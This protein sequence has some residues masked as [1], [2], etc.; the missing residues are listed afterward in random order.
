MKK[1]I[2]LLFCSANAI[3]FN[4]QKKY[5]FLNP[6]KFNEADLSKAKSLL[7]ENAPAEILYKS[8][9][10]MVDSNTGNLH[11]RY[12]YR[13][14]IYNKDKAEDWLNLE[15]PIYNVGTNR[16]SLGKFKAFTYNLENG[17]AVPV[18]VEKSSQYK[19]KENKYVTLTKFAFPSVKNGSVI[20]YQY[21]IISP[22]RFMIP[23]VLI[24]SDTPSLNTEYVFDTPINMSYNVNYTGGISPKYR[25]M[26]ERQLYGG[27][28][29]TYR[30]AYE[31]LTGF[32]TEKFVRNDRNFRTKISAELNSTNFGELKL[33]SSS[34]DQIAKR[35]Y[36]SDDFG[37]EIKRTKLARENMPA[38]VSEMKT[39]L[40]KANAIFSYVQKTFT[41]NKD[42]GVYTEDGIKKLLETKTGNAA[43][44]NLFLVM[45]LREAGLKADPLIISTVENGLINMVSPNISNMNFVLAAI[46]IDKQLHIYDA[47]SKQSSLDEIPLKNWNQYGILVTKDKA[48]QIQMSNVK[49]SNTYLTANA[50]INDDGSISGTY[51]DK[52][53]GAYAM[54][55]K[56]NYDDNAEKYKKQ[57]KENFSMDFT[58]INSKVLENGDFESTM[59]F[60]SS[61]LIDRVG[62]KMIINPMLFLSKNSNEFDQTEVRKYPI[63]FGSPITRTKKVIL[64]IPEGYKI[65]EMPK[66][67]RIVTEDKEI[68]YTYSV[69]QK[70]NMLEVTTTTKIG[71]SDYPKEYYPAFKQIWGVA[72][73]FENQ[74]ISLVKK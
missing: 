12:F 37:G 59:K 14:K 24:E 29:R 4:A 17:A 15:I 54:Y 5:E 20:E 1:I 61:N 7:D 6:P 33:Y 56:D 55:A 49:S 46:D 10:F 68:A 67:K 32:K 3:L 9:Y 26:E 31:N 42:K 64:E 16:E 34:W 2:V 35:L 58:D 13:V 74:V 72:S 22:F 8:A 39:D 52:D 71:S 44:I 28:Y 69:E 27:Q 73:K 23:E 53:T 51:S 11:K 21:E 45:M 25:E 36:D 30:F 65:E 62:K 19:S 41:W 57:Y 70:G 60:S 47:T 50:K 48:L 38:G 66:E 63:D 43:E 40:E 18:K